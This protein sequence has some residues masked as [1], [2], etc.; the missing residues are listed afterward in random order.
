MKLVVRHMEGSV[1]KTRV[2]T[3]TEH[4]H[5]QLLPS[6]VSCKVKKFIGPIKLSQSC[7]NCV[8]YRNIDISDSEKDMLDLTMPKVA[9][10]LFVMTLMCSD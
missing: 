1:T 8:V 3:N 7:W 5:F 2:S 4:A 9:T 10:V 6:K